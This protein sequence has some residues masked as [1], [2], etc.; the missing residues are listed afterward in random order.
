[1]G[2]ETSSPNANISLSRESSTI[3]VLITAEVAVGEGE[4]FNLYQGSPISLDTTKFKTILIDN[5]YS[6]Y[7]SSQN[8]ISGCNLGFNDYVLYM[9]K[10]GDYVVN[11]REEDLPGPC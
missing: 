11:R 7:D 2:N 9:L 6:L 1:M 8:P 10:P 3:C 5:L 4:S